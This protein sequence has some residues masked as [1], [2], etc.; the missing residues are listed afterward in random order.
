MS[1]RAKASLALALLMLPLVPIGGAAEPVAATWSPFTAPQPIN[2]LDMAETSDTIAAALSAYTG[3]TGDG[4]C[5]PTEAGCVSSPQDAYDLAILSV[6]NGF[7]RASDDNEAVSPQGRTHVAVSADGTTVASVGTDPSVTSPSTAPVLYYNRAAQGSNFTTTPTSIRTNLA[8]TTL[9]VAVSDD[10][11]RVAVLS[12]VNSNTTVRGF[13]FTNGI[14]AS[15]FT[16]T[17]PGRPNALAASADLNRLVVVGMAPPSIPDRAV[18]HTLT[19][20]SGVSGTPWYAPLG[21]NLTRVAVSPSGDRWAAGGVNGTAVLFNAGITEPTAIPAGGGKIDAVRF[22]GDGSRLIVASN[23]TLMGFDATGAQLASKWNASLP[24]NVNAL[25]ANHTGRIVAAA[26]SNGVYAYGDD[27]RELW[28]VNGNSFA[29]DVNANGTAIA[30]AQTTRVFA[31]AIPRALTFAF[32]NG[33]DQGTPRTITPGGNATYDLF[34]SNNGAAHELVTFSGPENLDVQVA[35]DPAVVTLAPGESRR[36]VATVTPGQLDAGSRSFNVSATSHTH[37]L[38][39]DVTLAFTLASVVDVSMVVNVTDVLAKVGEEHELLVGIRNAGSKVVAV[40][41]RAEQSPSAGDRW[42]LT[43]D[44]PSLTL[45]P[46]SIT[47]VRITVTPPARA[48]NG[49]SNAI[50]F[51][52]EGAEVADQARIVYR[53]NPTLGVEITPA[54]RVKYIEAGKDGTFNVTITNTGSLPRRF[55]A[56]YDVNETSGRAWGIDMPLDEFRLEPDQSR[57]LTIR[58][59]APV[60]AVPPDQL[61]FTVTARLVPEGD[62]PVIRDT[63]TLF[64]NAAERVDDEDDGEDDNVIPAAPLPFILVGIG[65]VAALLRRRRAA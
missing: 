41:L 26:T 31:A 30:W 19:Y 3:R 60:D 13:T 47:T 43:I 36:V 61:T 12:E 15:A 16:F 53:I 62:E 49:T 11:R 2:A 27:G 55:S 21:T 56:Y 22:S 20:A 59:T 14:L 17:T 45:A 24:A 63:E 44:P 48:E 35:F 38:V 57:T 46:N 6:A 50:T 42:N 34:I 28:H 54:A 52:L 8:G 51:F 65:L 25:D 1:P 33:E 58:V 29:V 18:V 64:A 4:T 10:G 40:S 7:V 5:L 23:T 39:D 37:D 9:G 32:E